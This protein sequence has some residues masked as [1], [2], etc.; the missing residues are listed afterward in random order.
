MDK[1]RSQYERFPYPPTGVFALP[2]RGQGARLAFEEGVR[3]AEK[4]GYTQTEGLKKNHG[5]TRI[6]IAGA[7]T[8]EPL[9]VADMH[10][11]ARELV[12]VDFSA[13]SIER[14]RRRLRF[15]RFM[16]SIHLRRLSRGGVLAPVRCVAADLRQWEDGVFDYIL[17]SNVLHHV[18][19][20]AALLTRLAGWLKPGG[21]LRLVT[22]PKV[23]RFWIGT[24]GRWLRRNGLTVNTL[25]LRRQ[26]R[27]VIGRLPPDHPL[28]CCFESHSE[29][30]RAAGI[31]DAFLHACEHPLSP[32]AWQAVAEACSL[33]LVGESQSSTSRSSFLEE[34]VPRTKPLNVW[35]KLQVLDDLLELTT[36]PV[37][38]FVKAENV[39]APPVPPV[40]LGTQERS[41]VNREWGTDKPCVLDC[42]ISPEGLLSSGHD[43]F[44][45]PSSPFWELAQG[46]RDADRLL[47]SVNVSA[48]EVIT[49]LREDVGPHVSVFRGQRELIGLAISDYDPSTLLDVAEPWR[50]A[51]W[52]KLDGLI[53]KDK[54]L[55][56]NGER[57]PGNTIALQAEWLQL[58]YGAIQ[59]H[60]DVQL[61]PRD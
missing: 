34:L 46:I 1:V 29:S 24:T 6:L 48:T 21:I 11:H 61:R 27:A 44:R 57:V 47:R 59:P 40:P 18:A 51:E 50:A 31:V 4:A 14:L 19:D 39:N 12:A 26:A 58:R 49:A 45:L 13:T 60:I 52:E 36:N 28:R 37:L 22:Y 5:G 38:W 43:A 25:N 56:T 15:A 32:T 23:S 41:A 20:P 54:T 35:R 16:D 53:G 10:P 7:G 55:Y 33:R 42:S 9:V 8:L 2:K 3:L 30:R 17:A